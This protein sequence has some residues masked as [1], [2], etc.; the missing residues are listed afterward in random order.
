MSEL[1]QM[2]NYRAYLIGADGH[3]E[4]R[5][6]LEVPDEATAREKA[7]LLVDGHAVELWDGATRIARFEPITRH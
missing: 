7:E 5:V 1:F 4:Q 6:D 2:G 3:I